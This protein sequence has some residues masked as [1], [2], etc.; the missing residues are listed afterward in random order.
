MEA[1]YLCG[2]A[3]PLLNHIFSV[4]R[5]KT[6]L[7]YWGA[8]EQKTRL[9][10]QVTSTIESDGLRSR[11]NPGTERF[12]TDLATCSQPKSWGR[13]NT[14]FSRVIFALFAGRGRGGARRAKE[15]LTSSKRSI[16]GSSALSVQGGDGKLD[17]FDTLKVWAN[18]LI[19]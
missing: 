11:R 6:G 15:G 3:N 14:C 19:L 7:G 10:I 4:S 18:M 8:T 5:N 12:A 13:S 16:A 1:G 17:E 2:A 9:R